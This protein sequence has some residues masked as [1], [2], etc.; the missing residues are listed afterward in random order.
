MLASGE[1][2][3]NSNETNAT[4]QA[5]RTTSTTSTLTTATSIRTTPSSARRLARRVNDRDHIALPSPDKEVDPLLEEQLYDEQ[6]LAEN[7]GASSSEEEPDVEDDGM[8]EEGCHPTQED[9]H[10]TLDTQD[11]AEMK[12]YIPVKLESS[13]NGEPWCYVAPVGWLPPSAQDDWHPNQPKLEKGEPEL[14]DV[15]DNPGGWST[16][17]YQA[18]FSQ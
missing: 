6:C 15:I 10:H 4:N 16:Y 12:D 3:Q 11:A 9:K 5:A 18:S 14:F 8:E 7:G 17:S 13:S 1:T 2:Q